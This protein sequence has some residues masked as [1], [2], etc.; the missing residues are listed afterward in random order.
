MSK[1]QEDDSLV[2]AF[3][4]ESYQLQFAEPS[5]VVSPKLLRKGGS[6]KEVVR[7]CTFSFDAKDEVNLQN[8]SSD[9]N[10]IEEKELLVPL[11]VCKHKQ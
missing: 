9:S 2:R 3:K 4:Q 11:M 10:S 6:F 5:F 7:R 1:N 8:V